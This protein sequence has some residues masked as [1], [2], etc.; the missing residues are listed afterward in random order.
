LR[1]MTDEAM[2]QLAQL[3]PA[4]MRGDYADGDPTQHYRLAFLEAGN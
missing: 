4:E 3:L 1:E 2:V